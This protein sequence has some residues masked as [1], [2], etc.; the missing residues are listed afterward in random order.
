MLRCSGGVDG[1]IHKA[2]CA[3]LRVSALMALMAAVA[4]TLL[5]D[6]HRAVADRLVNE[7]LKRQRP[8]G[9]WVGYSDLV[10]DSCSND[11]QGAFTLNY[12]TGILM[13]GL[14][15]YDRAF[16][17]ARILPA[18]QKS[19]NWL[20]TTQWVPAQQ[21]FQYAD[22]NCGSVG[23]YPAADL[24]GLIWPAWGYAEYLTGNA[25]I[26]TQGQAIFQGFVTVGVSSIPSVKHYDQLFRSSSHYLGYI[27][28]P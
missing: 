9:Q 13:E 14:I 26:F 3:G 22:V 5:G 20:W 18:I 7:I 21:A 16:G 8:N 1:R 28:A 11:G 17:D 24:T 25:T 27:T 6:N 10:P 19:L 4:A 15:L 12:M 23:T 2:H